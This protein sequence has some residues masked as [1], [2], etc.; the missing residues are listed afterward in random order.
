MNELL[1]TLQFTNRN[2]VVI[3]KRIIT[4]ITVKEQLK[5]AQ[6]ILETVIIPQELEY[7][8]RKRDV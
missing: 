5:K 1:K 2:L 6:E 4:G 8:K 3:S 7:Q